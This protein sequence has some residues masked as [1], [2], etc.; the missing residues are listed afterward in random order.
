MTPEEKQEYELALDIGKKRF[1]SPC[2]HSHVKNGICQNCLRK[3]VTLDSLY[4]KPAT[5]KL[6]RGLYEKS[7]Y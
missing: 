3:V 4:R 7:V 5:K 2:R 1:G 6:V